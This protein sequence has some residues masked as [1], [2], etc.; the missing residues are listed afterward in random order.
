MEGAWALCQLTG[1]AHYQEAFRPLI[2]NVVFAQYN[3]LED[4]LSKITEKTCAIMFETVQVRG[5]FTPVKPDL[6]K[7]YARFAMKKIFCS[8]WMRYSAAWDALE[9]CLLTS[10][11]I[12][13][14]M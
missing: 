1:N 12:F 3:N 9:R 5:G 4:V 11:M 13:F 6:F 7:R 10:T 14:R 2:G 8:F